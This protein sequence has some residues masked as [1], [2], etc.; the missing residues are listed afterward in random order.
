MPTGIIINSLSIILGGI[1]GGLFGDY[2]REDFK[3]N[4]NL[5]FGLASMASLSGAVM[6]GIYLQA[7]LRGWRN[8]LLFV[9]ALLLLD[10]SEERRVGK[11][12]RSRWSPYH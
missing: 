7:V 6:N 9:A 1:A 12:C 11:E 4:L 2:L 5:I 3:E 10:R 8:S